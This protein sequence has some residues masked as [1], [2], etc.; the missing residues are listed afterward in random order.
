MELQTPM[1]DKVIDKEAD[2]LGYPE[3]TAINGDAKAF[4]VV[5]SLSK[6]WPSGVPAVGRLSLSDRGFDESI[7]FPIQIDEQL[8]EQ[9]D[10]ADGSDR[11]AWEVLSALARAVDAISPWTADHSERV[12]RLALRMGAVVGLSLRDLDFLRRAALLHDIGKIGVSG[13]ILDKRGKL[14]D[15]ECRNIE[16][17]PQIGARILEPITAYAEMIPMVLQHHE[18][19]GGT[20][21]PDGIAGESICLGARIL[22]V[23]DVYD[24]VVSERPYRTGLGRKCAVDFIREGVGCKFDP[25]VVKA[26][27]EVMAQEEKDASCEESGEMAA[28]S[29]PFV[30]SYSS[31]DSGI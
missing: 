3:V 2:L 20:G 9:E 23:A 27:L 19:F 4:L 12:A 11:L 24:A 21:Y 31:I 28:F 30:F 1:V 17:H 6:E 25:K 5:S 8:G 29:E 13:T 7:P 16:E 15:D 18:Q 26:F 14:T 22:A 10:V